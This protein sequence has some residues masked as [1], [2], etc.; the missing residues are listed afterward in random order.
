MFGSLT[1]KVAAA[2][3]DLQRRLFSAVVLLLAY[4]DGH[5]TVGADAR[6]FQFASMLL[7]EQPDKTKKP[8]GY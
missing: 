6:S 4:T 7:Q 5:D 2:M 1:V 8:V 3:K